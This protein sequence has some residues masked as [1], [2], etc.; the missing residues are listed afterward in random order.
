MGSLWIREV[1]LWAFGYVVCLIFSNQ[2]LGLLNCASDSCKVVPARRLMGRH[3]SVVASTS[4]ISGSGS[5]DSL[6]SAR[7]LVLR[8]LGGYVGGGDSG[9]TRI[10]VWDPPGKPQDELYEILY[11]GDIWPISRGLF[12]KTIRTIHHI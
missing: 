1:Y 2:R 11:C 12:D 7:G 5:E 3:I 8:D 4:D 10:K 9:E 6:R